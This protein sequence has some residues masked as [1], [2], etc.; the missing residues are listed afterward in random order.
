MRLAGTYHPIEYILLRLEDFFPT[1]ENVGAIYL[2]DEK[3]NFIVNGDLQ[4]IAVFDHVNLQKI[5]S[6]R[7]FTSD[8]TAS[9]YLLDSP[10][11]S[12]QNSLYDEQKNTTLLIYLP[13]DKRDLCD[14][15]I[16]TFPRNQVMKGTSDVFSGISTAEK[17]LIA[18][19]TLNVVKSEFH[20]VNGERKIVDGFSNI[21]KSQLHKMDQ[22]SLGLEETKRLYL[23]SLRVLIHEFFDKL[24]K[25]YSCSFIPTNDLI[26]KVGQ[27]QMGIDAIYSN[28]RS[29]AELG[30]HLLFGEREIKIPASYFTLKDVPR[31]S[32]GNKN[33]LVDVDK[34]V[35]LLDR[36]E[37]AAEA[38]QKLDLSINGKNVAKQL[39]P[40]VTPPAISDAVK[41]NEKRIRF[42]LNQYGDKWLLIR[43][44]L[45]PIERLD[46]SNHNGIQLAM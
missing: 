17:S 10:I 12:K 9:P 16:L 19:F 18:V 6:K 26:E 42:L 20:R 1:L 8:W 46:D 38:L 24:S 3:L 32:D 15:L 30:Y 5:R 13:S 40:P 36:Y 11:Y 37:N 25:E 27:L 21:Q 44:F 39:N 23:N 35:H 7:S 14:V 41:K 34:T 4:E 28:L 2:L 43:K 45:K 33:Q 22:L 31:Y 29:A